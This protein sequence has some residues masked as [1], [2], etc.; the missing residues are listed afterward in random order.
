M[1]WFQQN[2]FKQNKIGSWLT[3]PKH[4]R[5]HSTVK[6]AHKKAISSGHCETTRDSIFFNKHWK[7]LENAFLFYCARG[8]STTALFAI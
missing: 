1:K 8:L 4:E 5:S 3:P 7:S 2:R 6:F